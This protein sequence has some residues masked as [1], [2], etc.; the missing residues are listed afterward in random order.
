MTILSARK[1]EGCAGKERT[2]LTNVKLRLVRS[3][4]FRMRLHEDAG[5][6]GALSRSAIELVGRLAW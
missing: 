3:F 1:E 5:F 4:G 2:G 6:S